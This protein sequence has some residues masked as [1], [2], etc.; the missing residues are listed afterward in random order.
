MISMAVPDL[1]QKI[2][3]YL[4]V[5]FEGKASGIFLDRIGTIIDGTPDEPSAMDDG[6]NNVRVAVK[7]LFSDTLSDDI[8]DQLPLMAKYPDRV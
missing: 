4:E 6:L 1:K 7:L 2:K 8:Y 3:E 5:R